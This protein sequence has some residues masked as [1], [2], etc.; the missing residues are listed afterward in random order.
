MFDR[1]LVIEDGR[2]LEDDQP[3]RLA[4]TPSRY[5]RLLDAER[6]VLGQLWDGKDWRRVLIRD[7]RAQGAV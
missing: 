1:V 7:G 6:E 4:A 5:Q 2:V 3:E